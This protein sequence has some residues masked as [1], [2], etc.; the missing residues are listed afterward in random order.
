MTPTPWWLPIVV[1]CVV[2]K[3]FV[4]QFQ[5]AKS[6]AEAIMAITF[7]ALF[8]CVAFAHEWR[9]AGKLG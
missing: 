6:R 5:F 1:G 9:E 7:E 8:F 4:C 3:L 2:A